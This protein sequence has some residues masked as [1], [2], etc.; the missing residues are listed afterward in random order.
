M[1]L[2]S[3][4][5]FSQTSSVWYESRGDS[6]VIA[7]TKERG[8]EIAMKLVERVELKDSVALLMEMN[9][10]NDSLQSNLNEQ[11][12]LLTQTN[13]VCSEVNRLKDEQIVNHVKMEGALEDEIRIQKKKRWIF[14]GGGLLGGLLLGI[15]AK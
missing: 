3:F 12:N 6:V 5:T 9:R 1:T 4:S 8:Q 10:I 14:A 2:L 7:M 15:L 11:I 13:D